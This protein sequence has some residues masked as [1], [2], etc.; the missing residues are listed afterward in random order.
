MTPIDGLLD[1]L[2]RAADVARAASRDTAAYRLGTR[3]LALRTRDLTDHGLP[4][5]ALPPADPRDATA[6]V[7]VL[8]RADLAGIRLDPRERLGPYGAVLATAETDWLVVADPERGKLLA[9]DRGTREALYYPGD[10]APP[11]RDRAEFLR[12]LLHWLAILDGH[13]VVHAGGLARDGRGLLVAGTGNAGK[14]TLVRA[15]LADGWS[16]L[17]DNVVEVVPRADGGSDLVSVY[18][19][20]KTRPGPVVPIPSSWP[21]AEWDDEARKHIHFLADELGAAFE[22]DAVEH[23]AT[24]VLDEHGSPDVRALPLG[25]GLLMVAPNTVAQ[26]PFLEREALQRTGALLGRA[27]LLT[28]GRLPVAEIPARLG[29]LLGRSTADVH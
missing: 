1:D 23:A 18:A 5:G 17:G 20:F 19:T 28:S 13:V 8:D 16:V 6:V 10:V 14:S 11:P 9:L 29:A 15:A 7:H 25:A 2:R 21:A 12:P 22:R 27:P 24:L 26:F 3:V 4:T